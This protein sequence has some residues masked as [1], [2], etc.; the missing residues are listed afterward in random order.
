[1]IW[2]VWT[3]RFYGRDLEN[4]DA[5]IDPNPLI[6]MTPDDATQKVQIRFNYSNVSVD[7]TQADTFRDILGFDSLVYGPYAGA[8]VNILAS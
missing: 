4:K 2:V 3:K 8:P 7:F 5:K 1:M 6:T